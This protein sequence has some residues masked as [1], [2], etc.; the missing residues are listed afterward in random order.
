ML[1]G[2]I[3]APRRNC[4]V[5]LMSQPFAGTKPRVPA[6]E[7]RQRM[8]NCPRP[9]RALADAI[10]AQFYGLAYS[11]MTDN[12]WSVQPEYL[13]GNSD[14]ERELIRGL[15]ECANS[16]LCIAPQP[17]PNKETSMI[18]LYAWGT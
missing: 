6:A 18:D 10:L 5:E 11:A 7:G 4:R 12:A 13:N 8:E 16:G 2:R 9:V 15:R 14:D 1:A 3:K 17:I